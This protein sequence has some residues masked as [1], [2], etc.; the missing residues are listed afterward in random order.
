MWRYVA[1]DHHDGAVRVHPLRH[2]EVAD[3]VVGDNV[4]QVVL[5]SEQTSVRHTV[6]G[7]MSNSSFKHK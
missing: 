6:S 1:Q 4:S 2:A 5:W 3:A 7:R